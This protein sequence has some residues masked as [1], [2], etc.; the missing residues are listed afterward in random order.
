MVAD[1]LFWVD[2]ANNEIMTHFET[3]KTELC[4]LRV[5]QACAVLVP[6]VLVSGLAG[7]AAKT[8]HISLSPW[9]ASLVAFAIVLLLVDSAWRQIFPGYRLWSERAAKIAAEIENLRGRVDRVFEQYPERTKGEQF[10]RAYG[11]EGMT[12]KVLE[13]ALSVAMYREGK[14][15]FVTA[16]MRAEVAIRVTA[17]IGSPFR[18]GP[19]DDPSRWGTYIDRLS[20]DEIRQYHNHPVHNGRTAPSPE[21]F[22]SSR[23]LKSSLN[24]HAD[25]LRSFIIYWNEIREWK[26]LEYDDDGKHWLIAEFD[27]AS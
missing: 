22:R 25:K 10:K 20:C 18:C 8:S 15:V 11:L 14:E 3:I 13:E 2:A 1:D 19:A 26:V 7:I 16:F 17:S 12:L 21:D 4:R 27:I 6:A 24:R 5:R 9:I 23:S